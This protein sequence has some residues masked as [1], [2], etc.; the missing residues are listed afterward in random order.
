[1]HYRALS[2]QS[3]T[4]SRSENNVINKVL[5][6]CIGNICRSPMA[7]GLFKQ[8][9]PDKAVFSA[10]LGAMVGDPADPLSIQLMSERGIDIRGHRARTLEGWMISETDLIV[11]M[12]Q[13]QKCFIEQR[14]PTTKGRVVRIGEEGN[15][16][17]PDPYLQGM[18]AFRRAFD[19]IVRGV[20][21][22]A[23][24]IACE[25]GKGIAYRLP[26]VRQFPVPLL[27]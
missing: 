2:A 21:C 16:D 18:P 17:V 7:E 24:Q 5:F 12:D 9:L 26:P 27:P 19:L 22:L 4:L 11:T 3:Q 13:T 8:A 25:S 15:Y 14:Y 1:V 20:D 23:E 6:V 10:G